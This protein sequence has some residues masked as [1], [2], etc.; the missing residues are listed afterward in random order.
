[1]TLPAFRDSTA[2]RGETAIIPV[3]A[4]E[5]AAPPGPADAVA[6]APTGGGAASASDSDDAATRI[7]PI[8]QDIPPAPRPVPPPAGRGRTVAVHQTK[9]S[10]T[11]A[12]ALGLLRFRLAE[13]IRAAYSR[14]QGRR[15][16]Q[17]ISTLVAFVVVA[18]ATAVAWSLAPDKPA[19]QR[20]SANDWRGAGGGADLAARLVAGTP[21]ESFAEGVAGVVPAPARPLPGW[22]SQQVAAGISQ[23]TQALIESR[24][25]PTLVR[26]HNPEKFLAL[27][28]P[29]QQETLRSEL[30]NGRSAAYASQ[31]ADGLQ[32]AGNGPRVEGSMTYQT[33]L[34]AQSVTVLQIVTTYVWAYPIAPT[35]G[36]PA[37][38]LIVIHDRITWQVTAPTTVPEPEVGL[39]LGDA[40]SYASNVDCGLFA[41]GLLAPST[42]TTATAQPDGLFTPGAPLADPTCQ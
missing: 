5:P 7:I 36:H 25:A 19:P 30:N 23:V 26:D 42:T 34:N 11:R 9:S 40:E 4:P 29:G 14:R 6:A 32:L 31:L 12:D 37:G 21:A 3:V 10:A 18:A 20:A 24:V 22:P 28:A 13:R 33:A 38:S 41:V 2:G 27:I 35:P 15:R 39:W 8:F 16:L 17:I 1:V